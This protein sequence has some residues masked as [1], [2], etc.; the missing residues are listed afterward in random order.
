MIDLTER[1]DAPTEVQRM[2]RDAAAAFFAADGPGRRL[3]E[4]RGKL[5]GHDRERWQRM[6]GLG[7]LGLCLPE[8]LGGSG[9]GAAGVRRRVRAVRD[10]S[11]RPGRGGRCGHVVG[12]QAATE[13]HPWS[14]RYRGTRAMPAGAGTA[15]GSGAVTS[16]DLWLHYRDVWVTYDGGMSARLSIG[17]V[18]RRTGATVPTVRYYEEIGLLPL[19][20]AS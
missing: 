5:P 6:A 2:L 18:A 20:K 17:L 8:A 11:A 7:W 13:P 1:L 16:Q 14:G 4:W 19:A 10:G 9:L 15:A 12:P 3:R